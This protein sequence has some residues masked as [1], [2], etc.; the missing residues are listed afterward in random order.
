MLVWSTGPRKKLWRN[1]STG[2]SVLGIH[3]A[4]IM[5]TFD[6]TAAVVVMT[7]I[8]NQN[9]GA[10]RSRKS[11]MTNLRNDHN[12]QQFVWNFMCKMMKITL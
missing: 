5:N 2:S 7:F 10:R 11:G 1:S 4:E 3:M 8:A 6:I 12:T 9:Y